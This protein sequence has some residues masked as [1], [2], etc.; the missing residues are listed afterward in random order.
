MLLDYDERRAVVVDVGSFR[1]RAGHS[2]DSAPSA[3][4]PSPVGVRRTHADAPSLFFGPNALH[5]SPTALEVLPTWAG[6]RVADWGLFETLLHNLIRVQLE[7]D[8]APSLLLAVPHTMDSSDKERMLECCFEKVGASGAFLAKSAAL[9]AFAVGHHTAMVVES[10]HASSSATPVHEG[11]ALSRGCVASPH[12]GHRIGLELLHFMEANGR[13]PWPR[14]RFRREKGRSG[15]PE[16]VIYSPPNVHQ[17]YD[18]WAM[19]ETMHSIKEAVLCV[20]DKDV[21]QEVLPQQHILPDGTSVS[22]G[23]ER[24][25]IPELAL[26]GEAGLPEMVTQSLHKCDHDARLDLSRALVVAG[27]TTLIDGFVSRLDAE[28]AQRLPTIGKFKAVVAPSR[29]GDRKHSV[30]LGGSILSSLGTF[31]QLWISASEYQEYGAAVVHR[32]CP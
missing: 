15:H 23:S 3:V 5:A 9:A 7:V 1:A 30:W 20:P 31:Q 13:P 24:A 4:L 8:W 14:H 21:S 11:Y 2:G 12:A 18:E 32:K 10:G 22:F 27:G 6:G 25:R 19:M 17:S 29:P 16:T 28:I 26:F